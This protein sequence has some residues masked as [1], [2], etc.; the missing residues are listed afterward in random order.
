MVEVKKN[1][2]TGRFQFVEP[3]LEILYNWSSLVTVGSVDDTK[4]STKQ[5][6]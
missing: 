4:H 6:F 1:N 2:V 5:Q 3:V